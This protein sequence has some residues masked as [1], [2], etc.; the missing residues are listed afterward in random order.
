MKGIGPPARPDNLASAGT[1]KST[2]STFEH[3]LVL[4]KNGTISSTNWETSTIS[5][6]Y[7]LPGTNSE[8]SHFFLTT[9]KFEY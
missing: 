8:N 5:K 2:I 4:S 3:S 7:R 9:A 6:H 1:K